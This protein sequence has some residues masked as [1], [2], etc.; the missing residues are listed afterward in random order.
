MNKKT[1]TILLTVVASV[2]LLTAAIGG[3]MAWLVDKSGPVTNT[4][5]PTTIGVTLTE[6][7]GNTY[8]MVPGAT[9]KKDPTVTI[10]A[11]SV[12]CYVFLMI[13]ERGSY[14]YNGEHKTAFE[15]ILEYE[16]AD[17]WTIHPSSLIGTGTDDDYIIYR[18]V[19]A[20]EAEAGKTYSIL[21][22]DQIKVLPT[23]TKEEL[24][25]VHTVELE[26]KAY[27][28]QSDHLVDDAG[29]SLNMDTEAGQKAIWKLVPKN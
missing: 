7:T 20:D 26:F 18:A 9:I 25:A 2:L 23:V 15:S 6:T 8:Q 29:N 14:D 5:T 24:A 11:G 19:S 12:P 21:K 3:T 1:R 4:F 13:N 17:G 22:D 10:K 16:F 28:I 27:V